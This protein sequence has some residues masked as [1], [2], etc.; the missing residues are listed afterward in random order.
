MFNHGH[1]VNR[2]IWIPHYR[3]SD[4]VVLCLVRD[5]S[6]GLGFWADERRLVVALTRARRRLVGGASGVGLHSSENAP[7]VVLSATDS[8]APLSRRRRGGEVVRSL[9]TY[10]QGTGYRLNVGTGGRTSDGGGARR[11]GDGGGASRAARTVCSWRCRR[12]PS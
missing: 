6:R 8:D 1:E 7:A 2:H 12:Q 10:E 11:T 9:D 3:T 5:G 4:T